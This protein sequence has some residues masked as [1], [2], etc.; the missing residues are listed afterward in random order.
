MLRRSRHNRTPSL[1]SELRRS[2]SAGPRKRRTS[3]D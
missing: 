2:R 3:D 1:N